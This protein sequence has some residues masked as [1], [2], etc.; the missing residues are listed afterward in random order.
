MSKVQLTYDH[1]LIGIGYDVLSWLVFAPVGSHDR[2]R[3]RALDVLRIQRGQSIL[4]LGCG[5][6]GMTAKLLDRGAR[7]L[8]VD[9]SPVMIDRAKARVPNGTFEQ[10]EITAYEP[11]QRYDRV[12]FAFVLHE[13]ERDDRAKALALAKGALAPGGRIAVVDHARPQSG[14]IA[15]WVS[16]FVHAFEPESVSALLEHGFE[17][18]LQAAGLEIEARE[19]LAGGTAVALLIKPGF[20]GGQ[21]QNA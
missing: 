3:E 14:A 2:L 4:E 21:V 15:R 5:T 16:N 19:L 9:R 13:L 18:E 11:K 10:S 17:P 7:V 1:P 6:G 12:F 20:E 8:S